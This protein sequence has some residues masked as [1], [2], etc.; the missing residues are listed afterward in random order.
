[1]LTGEISIRLGA[2]T[3]ITRI[4]AAADSGDPT[5]TEAL[6]PLVYS[7]LRA[8]ARQRLN[9][10][11]PGQTLDATGLV[12]EAYLRLMRGDDKGDQNW[13]GRGHF[14]AA[15]AEVMRRIL[16]E[17]ARR[18]SRAKHGGKFRRDPLDVVLTAVKEPADEVLA[19]DE[20]LEQLAA[21]DA[22]SAE[23]V[24]LHFFAAMTLEEV[25]AVLEISTRTAHR[26]WAFA[27]A[28]LAERLC[29]AAD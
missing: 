15:A 19:V 1:M 3:D 20:S 2:M 6:L 18:K 21:I 22:R 13:D 25:A 28:W 8:L 5:A 23:V 16:V 12:H 14:F 10:E 29:D 7:E 26:D 24:K 9:Q 27:R 4:L 11:R 17:N